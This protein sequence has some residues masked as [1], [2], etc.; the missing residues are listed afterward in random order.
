MPRDD[1]AVADP[2]AANVL[3]DDDAVAESDDDCMMIS[4]RETR[5]NLDLSSS[6]SS[7][8]S[9]YE[10]GNSVGPGK[11]S[12]YSDSSDCDDEEIE[13]EKETVT[14]DILASYRSNRAMNAVAYFNEVDGAS[15]NMLLTDKVQFF[16]MTKSFCDTPQTFSTSLGQT[17]LYYNTVITFKRGI[18]YTGKAFHYCLF[19]GR[20][21]KTNNIIYLGS[22]S[23]KN[24]PFRL[25][26]YIYDVDNTAVNAVAANKV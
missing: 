1:D 17:L 3:R 20:T 22:L 6:S 14:S 24:N 2:V 7:T 10:R 19:E 15:H 16:F 21:N 9:D 11:L 26:C 25:R 12:M 18:F 13:E 23:N 5:P 8:G 4:H